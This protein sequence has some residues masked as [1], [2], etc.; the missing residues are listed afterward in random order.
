MISLVSGGSRGLGLA[1]VESLKNFLGK[2]LPSV[3]GPAAIR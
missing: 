2:T 1:I 3:A